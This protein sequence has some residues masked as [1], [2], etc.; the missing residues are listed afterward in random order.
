MSL[1]DAGLLMPIRFDSSSPVLAVQ[2]GAQT[3][4]INLSV[5][6][7]RDYWITGDGRADDAAGN[8]DILTIIAD[9][10][11][12]QHPAAP[13]VTPSLSFVG[14]RARV[15]FVCS[16]AL[17]LEWGNAST[18]LEPA[19][20][21][22][23]SAS[24]PQ[25]T[26]LVAANQLPSL[27]SPDA[28]IGFDTRDR[29]V[30]LRGLRRTMTG[31][32]VVTDFGNTASRRDVTFNLLHQSAALQEYADRPADAFELHWVNTISKGMRFRLYEEQGKIG[33]GLG[34]GTY[35]TDSL[36]DPLQRS[37]QD[38]ARVRWDVSLQMRLAG[39]SVGLEGD[40]EN[41]SVI[42]GGFGSGAF[43]AG[44]GF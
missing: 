17:S 1:S 11:T 33:N 16:P 15:R 37:P 10:I 6:V 20:F 27:W 30:I 19:P 29:R 8:A 5:S 2:V 18:T 13:S 38:P 4:L 24:T 41:D 31:R 43:G 21:G 44:F 14:S 35:T 22:F 23:G 42:Q 7:G 12:A 32:V 9:A 39:L 25:S 3:A 34:F 36:Q 28:P 26:N 40:V